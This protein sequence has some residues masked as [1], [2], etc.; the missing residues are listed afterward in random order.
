MNATSRLGRL[1]DSVR[2]RTRRGA[3][4]AAAAVVLGSAVLSLVFFVGALM[5]TS[6][7]LEYS[8]ERDIDARAWA[9]LQPNYGSAAI[10]AECHQREHDRLTSATHAGIGCESCHGPLLEHS[11]ASP[12]TAAAAVE[13]ETPNDGVCLR[14]HAS[15]EGRPITFRQVVPSEHYVST[16][17]QCHDPH[18]GIS[19]RPP[20]VEHPLDNLPPCLV[21]HGPDG[22]KTM[23]IR[24]PEVTGSDKPCLACHARGRGPAEEPRPQ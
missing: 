6:P 13:I 5:A 1:W 12:G 14:C 15:T 7:Y 23:N 24:H 11:L 18:T 4:L 22:F 9:A 19:N 10:C 21:C 16:C 8:L 3:V 17:L 20:I 2:P